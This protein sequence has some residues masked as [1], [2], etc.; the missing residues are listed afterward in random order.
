ML[1]SNTHIYKLNGEEGMKSNF[2]SD[3]EN[4]KVP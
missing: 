3:S 4:S 2:R 1:F